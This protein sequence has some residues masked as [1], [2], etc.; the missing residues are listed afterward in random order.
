MRGVLAAL[1]LTVLAA[2]GTPPAEE[3]AEEEISGATEIP[4][5]AARTFR[6]FERDGYRIVDMRAAVVNWGGEAVGQEQFD[7]LVLV[8]R[9]MEA[10]ELTGDLAGATLIRTPV[11]RIASNYAHQEAITKA[12]GINHRLVAVGGA[13]SYDDELRSKARSG[14]IAQ[15]GYGWHAPPE[16]DALLAARPDVLLM[17]MEDLAAAGA[18]SRIEDLGI[19][20]VPI[21]TENEPDYMGKVDYV[22]LIGMLTGKEAEADDYVQMVRCNVAAIKAR[23]AQYPT[24]SVMMAWYGNGD[25]WNPTVRNADA[26]LLRDANGR[27][28]FEEPEDRTRDSFTQI[29]TE[30]LIARGADVDCWIIRDTHSEP[31]K[32][33]ATLRRFKAYRENCLFAADGMYKPDADAFDFYETAVIRPDLLLGD[34]ARMLHPEMRDAPFR[35]F[36]PDRQVPR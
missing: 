33:V 20:V 2:C 29:S 13:K 8:P 23:A 14:E 24:R 11:M 22:R 36:R 27:N 12:L 9:E 3:P 21:F 15:I 1:A 7:R 19:P 31:F 35:Y 10:P 5:E 30:E 4:M 32:D 28:P 34:L 25:R 6:V 18:K 26:K 16:L 17:T